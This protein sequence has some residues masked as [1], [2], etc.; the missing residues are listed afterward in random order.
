[1]VD[2]RW[3]RALLASAVTGGA[4]PRGGAG[5][6]ALY[7]SVGERLDR[8]E[9]DVAGARLT[10]RESVTLPALVQYG[11]PSPD[12]RFFYVTSSDRGPGTGSASDKHHL[13]AFRVDPASGALTP[14]GPA[15]RLPARPIHHTLDIPGKH[16]LVAYN[17]PSGVN[18]Y[19]INGDGTLGD[20]VRQPGPLDG[21]IYAHQVRVAPSNRMVILVTRGNDAA[22]D[23]PEDPGALKVFGYDNGVLTD[24]ASVAPGTGLGFGPR[25]LDFHPTRPWV[26]VSIERQNQLYVYEMAGDTLKPDALYVKENP[27][28][29]GNIRRRQH[30]G[31]VHVHPNGRF[32]Y[33]PNRNGATEE[34]N[35]QQV[36]AGGENNM[37]VYRLDLSTG[38]P[39]PIQHI[40]T[41]GI[42]PRTFHIDPSGRLLVVCNQTEL[43]VREAGGLRTVP[44][45][46]V[47]YRIGD[48]GRLTFV[49]K[50]D[51]ETG[52]KQAFWMG[53]VPL[54]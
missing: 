53:M 46:L 38:E 25:H 8:Y 19:R 36:W 23:K 21:G 48:D 37:A 24:R 34:V 41:Q 32:V 17:N 9:V 29:P 6:V 44:A 26:F 50:L 27:I 3:W 7:A 13:S 31:T 1:M 33:V 45:S 35:G 51:L 11:W 22:G 42:T 39:E 52:G 5:G 54:P 49:E 47:T 10:R 14:H 15:V 4:A 20:E 30:V 43:P 12:R 18:V 16:V 28:D 40:E 2:Q